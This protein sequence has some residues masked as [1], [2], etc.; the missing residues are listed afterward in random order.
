[1]TVQLPQTLDA[2]VTSYTSAEVVQHS[3]STDNRSLCHLLCLVFSGC[4]AVYC[5][6]RCQ[7]LLALAMLQL[8]WLQ[9]TILLPHTLV[10]FVT[11]YA[12]AAVAVVQY[13]ATSTP[14]SVAGVAPGAAVVVVEP[15][16]H[17]AVRAGTGRC[18]AIVWNGAFSS[19]VK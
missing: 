13:T 19:A 1:M 15:V 18:G 16:I 17:I 10:A 7:M 11:S 5:L 14:F 4:S 3:A 2:F 12:S 6:H 8:L 9:C